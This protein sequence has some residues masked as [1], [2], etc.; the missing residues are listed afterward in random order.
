MLGSLLRFF[1]GLYSEKAGVSVLEADKNLG[2]AT[3]LAGI[4]G[5]VALLRQ[6][7][8]LVLAEEFQ[9]GG[10]GVHLRGGDWKIV[11]TFCAAIRADSWK[12]YANLNRLLP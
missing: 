4:L 2:A 8:Q 3:A 7:Q 11:L 5:A 9:Q 1:P 12:G 10:Q 6:L